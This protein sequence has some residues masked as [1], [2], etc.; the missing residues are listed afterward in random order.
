MLGFIIF[1]YEYIEDR[2]E[3]ACGNFRLCLVRWL[4]RYIKELLT[5]IL[6]IFILDKFVLSRTCFY[7]LLISVPGSNCPIYRYDHRVG[8]L[9]VLQSHLL[10]NWN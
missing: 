4:I 3:W 1:L 10:I 5:F 2:V 6:P 7:L 9:G 8:F